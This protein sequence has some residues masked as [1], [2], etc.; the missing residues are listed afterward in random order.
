MKKMF[1]GNAGKKEAVYCL[2]LAAVAVF[3]SYLPYI[4]RGIYLGADSNFHLARMES[5]ADGLRNG[6]FPVKVHSEMCFG[7]G[8]GTGFFYS[9]IPLYFPA[10][11]L[12]AGLSLVGAYKIFQLL[13][14]AAVWGTTFYA[15]CRIMKRPLPAAAAAS[16]VL[17]SA[18]MMGSVYYVATLGHTMAMVFMPLAIVGCLLLLQGE[19]SWMLA[20]G[21]IGLL[22]THTISSVITAAVCALLVLFYFDKVI[23]DYR[24]ILRI[25][26]SAAVSLLSTITWWLPMLEQMSVQTYKVSQPWT[27]VSENVCTLRN[28]VIGDYGTGIVI[29]VALAIVILYVI[30]ALVRREKVSRELIVLLIIALIFTGITIWPAFWRLTQPLLNFIQFPYRFYFATTVLTAF[31]FGL[32]LNEVTDKIAC[33]KIKS[34]ELLSGIVLAVTLVSAVTSYG[35]FPESMFTGAREIYE[36]RKITQEVRGVGGGEEWLPLETSGNHFDTPTIAYD[37]AGSGAEGT[38][39]KGDTIFTVYLNMEKAYYDIPY[40]YYYG[41]RAYR[42]DGT[43]LSVVKGDRDGL[44]RVQLPEGGSGVEKITVVYRKTNVQKAAYVIFAL[45]IVAA[46]AV[47]LWKRC[48]KRVQRGRNA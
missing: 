19:K 42:E 44:V 45:W 30:V 12:L 18:R 13:L 27:F 40:V 29:T 25:A 21:F 17:L 22:L 34:P 4:E 1:A 10:L 46:G 24:I 16:L 38:K 36:G 32:I 41:Y 35:Y 5:L 9:D 48:G 20:L 28:L 26:L 31:A 11:L 37:E 23:G 15:G 7:Y 47:F 2:I 6:V 43:E 33:R 14:L 8:Y 3:L 39:E